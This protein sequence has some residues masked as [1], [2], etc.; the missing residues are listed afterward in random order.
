MGCV[1]NI[2]PFFQFLYACD[3]EHSLKKVLCFHI[4]HH[5]DSCDS[6]SISWHAF[7]NIVSV[8]YESECSSNLTRWDFF[9][10][11]LNFK[12]LCIDDL[13]LR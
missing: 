8:R 1:L 11:L 9:R 5:H 7:V 6:H 2:D 4:I 12:V 13:T 3:I 10:V